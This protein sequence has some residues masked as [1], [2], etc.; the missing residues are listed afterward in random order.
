[1]RDERFDGERKRR[2]WTSKLLEFAFWIA[3]AL[4]TAWV[5][6]ENVNTILPANNF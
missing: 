4:V 5:L 6:I 1:M 3:L 2:S